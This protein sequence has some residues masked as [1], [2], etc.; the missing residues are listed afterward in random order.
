METLQKKNNVFFFSFKK[1]IFPCMQELPKLHRNYSSRAI[2]WGSLHQTEENILLLRH[3]DIY[4][5]TP[6][7]PRDLPYAIENLMGKNTR[8]YEYSVQISA[9]QSFWIQ[10]DDLKTIFHCSS[11]TIHRAAETAVRWYNIQSLTLRT[12]F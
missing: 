5:H 7:L 4:N 3:T 6:V 12:V 1:K 9:F 2:I 10:N 8:S 11:S